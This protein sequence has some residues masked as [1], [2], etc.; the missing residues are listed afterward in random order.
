MLCSAELQSCSRTMAACL[1]EGT[2]KG[3]RNA[4][5]VSLTRQTMSLCRCGTVLEIQWQT[6]HK[7]AALLAPMRR[8][9]C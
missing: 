2:G 5:T 4:H 7:C 1:W 8:R 6:L 9:A 3:V